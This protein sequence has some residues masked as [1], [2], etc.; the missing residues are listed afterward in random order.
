MKKEPLFSYN[1]NSG[2][3][4]CLIEDKDGNII[5]GIAKCH[6]DDMDMASEKTGC[7]FAYRRAYIKVLQAYKKELKTE[8]RALNQ[9]YYSLN[10]S[11][12]FNPK[13]YENKMLQR[14]I[15]QK[16]EDINYVN[17]SIENSKKELRYIIKEKDKFYQGIR[18]HRNEAKNLK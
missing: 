14:Q 11:K 2:E 3:A 7:D 5:Y 13:S 8:L 6:P 18:K 4:S 12:H 10:R 9:L 16:Q 15:R 1:P 17:D